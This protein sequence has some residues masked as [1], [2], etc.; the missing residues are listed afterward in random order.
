MTCR[1]QYDRTHSRAG[2]DRLA[3][4]RPRC[5]DALRG[6]LPGMEIRVGEV[7]VH[8]VEH[9]PDRA[10]MPHRRSR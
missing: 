10:V 2:R 1:A 4:S 5:R 9:P 7:V 8:Y 6:S 3:R